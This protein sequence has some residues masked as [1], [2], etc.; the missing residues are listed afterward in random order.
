MPHPIPPFLEGQITLHAYERWLARKAAAHLKRDRKRGYENITAA[1]YRDSIHEAVIRSNGN[2]TYT[3]EALEWQRISQ[4]NNEDSKCGRHAY[5]AKFALLPT[6]DHI[7]SAELT[8]GLC[9]CSWRTNDAKNDLSHKSFLE[10]CRQVLEYA[11][12]PV[13]KD[14]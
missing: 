5:K 9:I 11:G 2:D 7:E 8:S 1:T 12:Y 3:G 13:T 10:L 6:V 14:A 4:Y